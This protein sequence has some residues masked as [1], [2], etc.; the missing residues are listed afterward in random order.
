[1]FWKNKLYALG[2][3]LLGISS[4]WLL[5][6]DATFFVISVPFALWIFF[7]REDIFDDSAY[8]E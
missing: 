8:Y 6:W 3:L 4:I 7:K 2:F 5:D 1:M